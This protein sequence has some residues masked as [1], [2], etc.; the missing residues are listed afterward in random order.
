MVRFTLII[1]IHV[2]G[3]YFFQGEKLRRLKALKLPYLL[4]HILI[5]CLVLLTFSP[6]LLHISFKHALLF[7]LING[8]FHFVV[9]YFTRIYKKIYWHANEEKYNFVVGLDV[10]LHLFILMLSFYY[11]VPD[12]FNAPY[13]ID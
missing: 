4:E 11:L 1:L 13:F 8:L 10:V 9:D 12:G 7:S 3:D 6:Y 5:Y 2:F